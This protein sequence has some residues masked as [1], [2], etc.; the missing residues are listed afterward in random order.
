MRA[1]LRSAVWRFAVVFAVVALVVGFAASVQAFPPPGTHSVVRGCATANLGGGPNEGLAAGWRNPSTGAI[2][3][4]PIAWPYLRLLADHSGS[5]APLHGL[6]PGVKALIVVTAGAVV[7]VV[8]PANERA[9]LSLD[10]SYIPPRDARQNLFRVADGASQV[11]FK[12]CSSSYE[13][14]QTEFAGGFLVA[15]AQCARIDIYT[16]TSNRPLVRQIPFGVP[17]RSC[18]PTG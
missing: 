7:R 10:Y 11:T 14:P 4:G 12:A 9:R 8:I 13:G 17:G 5:L 16:S 15:G 3:A 1:P 6:A 2:V 18:L